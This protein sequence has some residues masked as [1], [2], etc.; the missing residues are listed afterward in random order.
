M[1][2]EED[3]MTTRLNDVS[4][5]PT[6]R[7]IPLRRDWAEFI[8]DLRYVG[9][10]AIQISNELST[11]SFCGIDANRLLAGERVSLRRQCFYMDAVVD[12]WSHAFAAEQYGT[13]GYS[14]ALRIYNRENDCLLSIQLDGEN[15]RD[16]FEALVSLYADNRPPCAPSATCQGCVRA[17]AGACAREC[18]HATAFDPT[19]VPELL[20][21]L[22]DNAMPLRVTVEKADSRH[23]YEGVLTCFRR[24][25]DG[26]VLFDEGYA[27]TI[28]DAKIGR[29][30]LSE[31]CAAGTQ[32]IQLYDS[33]YRRALSL[34][35]HP[36]AGATELHKWRKI[37]ASL[38][39]SAAECVAL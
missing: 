36:G 13:G 1:F 3:P 27:L 6:E 14:Y 26:L 18:G 34:A 39:A 16:H 9:S 24:V 25:S 32:A 29:A 28:L 21:V 20:E 22:T 17:R 23:C 37:T 7:R 33:G 12:S 4:A 38:I 10:T 19:L 11:M 2:D 15:A 30:C 31:A 5:A 35:L 8:S